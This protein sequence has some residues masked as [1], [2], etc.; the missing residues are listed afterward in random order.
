MQT[1]SLSGAYHACGGRVR[2]AYMLEKI[3][4]RNALFEWLVWFAFLLSFLSL[5]FYVALTV[6][7]DTYLA[8]AFTV[9][10]LFP[11][12]AQFATLKTD[13][14]NYRSGNKGGSG[15]D[16]TTLYVMQCNNTLWCSFGTLIGDP[17]SV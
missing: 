13:L 2:V 4:M 12:V 10:C 7:L 15:A 17:V 14:I 5:E 8:P 16:L 9:S 1:I 3:R 11:Y 6:P